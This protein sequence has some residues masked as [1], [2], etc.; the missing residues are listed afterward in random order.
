LEFV[1]RIEDLAG[2]RLERVGVPTEND[3]K[4]AQTKGILKKLD[5]VDREVLD[6]FEEPA[7]LLLDQYNG[8][9]TKALKVALAYCSGHYKHKIPST[10]LLTG[11]PGFNTL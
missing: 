5:D 9:A 11:R 3:L 1:D 10:S 2:I 6:M 8:D 7:R 4:K